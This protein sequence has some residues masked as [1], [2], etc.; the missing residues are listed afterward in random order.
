M[1][2][3]ILLT[4]LCESGKTLT[5]TQFILSEDRET[6]TSVKENVGGISME[7]GNF[8]LV[9][10]PGHERL[11]NKFFDQFKASARLLVF[12]VDS[13]TL[14]KDVRDVADFL[15][16]VLADKAV[17]TTPIIIAC[18]KQDSA[19]AKGSTVIK[20]L[21]EKELNLVRQTRT[22]QL[23]SVDN[24]VSN[25]VFLGRQGKDFEFAQLQQHVEFV[26]CSAKTRDLEGLQGLIKKMI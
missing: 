19:M 26:E 20:T 1:R 4:G 24:S 8:R 18:N 12:T 11:R 10:I 15:Y 22:N 25:V 21:L 3:D 13:S 6:Y 5:W 2:R 23:Q 17:A 14:Q 9:D 16:T 7:K